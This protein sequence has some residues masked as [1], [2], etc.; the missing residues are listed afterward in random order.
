MCGLLGF[1]PRKGCKVD[2]SYFL[3][4]GSIN[5]VRG[6]DSF[7]I[8][9]GYNDIVKGFGQNDSTFVD[10]YTVHGENINK[11][12]QQDLTDLP[13]LGHARKSS[14]HKG[15]SNQTTHPHI[16]IMNDDTEEN[17]D[18]AL[19]HNGTIKND[20][21]LATEYNLSNF[22]KDSFNWTDSR[23]I[24]AI[25][26]LGHHDVLKKYE[27]TAALLFYDK[28]NFY[29]WKGAENNVE[30]RPLF[31]VMADE[32]VYFSSLAT[33]LKLKGE[34][35]SMSGNTLSV[36]PLDGSVK[37]AKTTIYERKD[38]TPVVENFM[39]GYSQV[40]YP[41]TTGTPTASDN[42][43]VNLKRLEIAK[44][45]KFVYIGTNNSPYFHR[46]MQVNGEIMYSKITKD[47][48]EIVNMASGNIYQV[49]GDT[50]RMTLREFLSSKI[51]SEPERSE[52]FKLS[53]TALS[54]DELIGLIHIIDDFAVHTKMLKDGWYVHYTYSAN[55]VDFVIN[56]KNEIL[57]KFDK[58][59]S[60][61]ICTNEITG[62]AAEARCINGNIIFT[63][64]TSN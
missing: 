9:V 62:H 20:K 49:E 8:S 23:I 53:Y 32:G 30:E 33:P 25:L 63:D 38:I 7:G 51:T 6:G 43:A 29:A 4:L 52:I 13:L 2:F 59:D 3:F 15:Y 26:G 47:G 24:A 48:G 14:S 42:E 12:A 19:V 58:N 39:N 56:S 22:F 37:A 27:G 11:L 1:I 21:S 57:T 10:F 44:N 46:T 54:R 16:F 17:F 61:I 55:D 40:Q 5:D 18:F 41:K 28:L 31:Y 64:L 50:P 35:K 36:I 45:G 60:Y 34:V